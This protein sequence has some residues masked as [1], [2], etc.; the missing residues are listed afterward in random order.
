MKI[1]T[2]IV[3]VTICTALALVTGIFG[4]THLLLDEN[5]ET[6]ET[7]AMVEDCTLVK[8]GLKALQDDLALLCQDYATWDDTYAFVQSQEK[9]YLTSNMVPETFSSSRLDTILIF[10]AE[11]TLIYGAGYNRSNESIVRPAPALLTHL[12]ANNLATAHGSSRE[13]A[14]GLVLLPQGPMMFSAA[15]VLRSSGDGPAKGMLVFGRFFTEDEI[16]RIREVT[17]LPVVF[18]PPDDPAAFAGIA[19]PQLPDQ[20]NTPAVI[21]SADRST[22]TGMTLFTDIAGRPA[23]FARIDV[24]RDL[25]AS[26]LA[27][28]S[29]LIGV[30]IAISAGSGLLLVGIIYYSV[31]RRFE[32][33]SRTVAAIR[34]DQDFSRRLPPGKTNEMTMLSASVNDLLS[35]L[36]EYTAEKNRYEE[37]L[38]ESREEYRQLFH[39][40]N[41]AIYVIHQKRFSRCNQRALQMLGCRRDEAISRSPLDFAPE[42]QPDGRR[43]AEAIEE[44]Y[45][46]A[47]AGASPTFEWRDQRSDG[48]YADTEVTLTRFDLQSG[49]YLLAIARDITEKKQTE[50]LKAEAFARIEQN[51]EQ[52]AILNDEIRNPLQVILA[53]AEM[54][55]CDDAEIVMQQVR[56]INRLVDDLD[57]GYIES[58]KVREFLRKHYEIGEKED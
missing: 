34:E 20:E 31:I 25:Y 5:L 15:P 43:S 49:P 11:G 2:F 16:A 6:S 58:D 45:A 44:Y 32:D 46:M 26:H 36:E 18:F 39:S 41:D 57:A 40:A 53:V 47:C 35:F 3:L 42:F 24:P 52:F 19:E 12:R 30:I 51:L 50:H 37:E 29:S 9:S 8:H 28:V 48:S 4:A 33:I 23:L 55:A 10:D 38:K 17:G 14:S 22:I 54:N 1:L 7:S 27:V 21:R 13:V 56:C